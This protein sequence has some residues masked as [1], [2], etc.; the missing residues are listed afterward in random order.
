MKKLDE[1]SLKRSKFCMKLYRRPNDS[2]IAIHGFSN[3]NLMTS[4]MK[5]LPAGGCYQSWNE[6]SL[7]DLCNHFLVVISLSFLWKRKKKAVSVVS[8]VKPWQRKRTWGKC[9]DSTCS[10][11]LLNSQWL[12]VQCHHRKVN[13]LK[14]PL[15]RSSPCMHQYSNVFLIF[16]KVEVTTSLVISAKLQETNNNWYTFLSTIF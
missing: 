8:V 1:K 7:H 9:S 16:T 12:R 3:P 10:H 13:H 14:I 15:N 11:L 5:S 6:T 2:T 4:K